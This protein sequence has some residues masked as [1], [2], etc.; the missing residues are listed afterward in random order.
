MP[1]YDLNRGINKPVE[2]KGLVG[3]NIYFLVAGIGLTF[4]LF[5][6]MYLA[7]VPLVITMLVTFAV[8]GGMWA[9]VFALNRKYGEHGLMKASA[10]RSSPKFI[11]NRQS[12]LFQHLNEDRTGRA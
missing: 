10:R 4:V 2:F 5:V 1:A 8:G 6:A 7:G 9:G 3:S 12:R 11:T